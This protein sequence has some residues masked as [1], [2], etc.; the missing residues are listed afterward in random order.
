MQE[1]GFEGGVM[2]AE[3][4]RKLLR[5]AVEKEGSLRSLARRMGCSAPFVSDVLRGNREPSGPILT[6]LNLERVTIP[7]KKTYRRVK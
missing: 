5:K 3:K 2:D 4:V 6:F 1:A 7:A